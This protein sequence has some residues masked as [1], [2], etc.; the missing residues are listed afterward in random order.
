MDKIA[1]QPIGDQGGDLLTTFHY[2]FLIGSS[3]ISVFGWID[4]DNNQAMTGLNVVSNLNRSDDNKSLDDFMQRGWEAKRG[5]RLVKSFDYNSYS[6]CWSGK[7]IN[8]DHEIMS[9]GTLT[10]PVFPKL[11]TSRC[12]ARSLSKRDKV[13]FL[14]PRRFDNVVLCRAAYMGRKR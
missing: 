3:L 7:N 4:N 10:P 8:I 6:I 2:W 9:V 5:T 12:P 13:T 11:R 1:L 14:V